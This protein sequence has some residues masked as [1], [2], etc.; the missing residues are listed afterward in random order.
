MENN[1][2]TA[3]LLA[4][5]DYV[6][7]KYNATIDPLP[8]H[9]LRSMGGEITFYGTVEIGGTPFPYQFT[10]PFLITDN[11][12]E[13]WDLTPAEVTAFVESVAKNPTTQRLIAAHPK[14]IFKL[15][16]S[17]GLELPRSFLNDYTPQLTDLRMAACGVMEGINR[18]TKSVPLRTVTY[19]FSDGDSYISGMI[20]GEEFYPY[21]ATL[22]LGRD[23]PAVGLPPTLGIVEPLTVGNFDFNR[24]RFSEWVRFGLDP[25]I[26]IP[27][28]ILA[29]QTIAE[30]WGATPLDQN[31]EQRPVWL[32][33]EPYTFTF[34]PTGDIQLVPCE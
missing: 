22:R 28:Q 34:T 23:V 14:I 13:A 26:T 11:R 19:A 6:S 24:N 18:P 1:P 12:L 10:A 4:E 31:I 20:E 2:S 8:P 3:Q 27:E 9:F 17:T 16:Y 30:V 33:E 5:H 21:K 15:A 25:E 29:Y 32:L 7:A